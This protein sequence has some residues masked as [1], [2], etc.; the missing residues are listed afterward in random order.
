MSQHFKVTKNSDWIKIKRI[1]NF[2][3]H[4]CAVYL[5]HRLVATY[6]EGDSFHLQ[7][8]YPVH[9]IVVVG[10]LFQ[11]G[12]VIPIA[13]Q[14][15]VQT[16]SRARNFKSGDIL[17]ASDNVNE[18][19][20]GY[21]GHSAIVVSDDQLIESPGG[22]PAIRKASIQQFLEKHPRHAQF[23][24]KS[25]KL[26]KAAAQYAEEYLQE[27]KARVEKGEKKP[28]FSYTL[29]QSLEDP[30]EYIYCSKLVWLSYYKGADYKLENDYLWFSPEDL[31]TNLKDNKDFKKIYEHENVDFVVNT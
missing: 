6:Y 2:A 18:S 11:Y 23:R 3:F 5:D 29:S 1:S 31:Y 4:S 17:V 16:H 22:D 9:H 24:P 13:E 27:Y 19:L 28:V 12:H 21:I 20:T 8:N 15:F 26:G 10:H 7:I 14:F 25:A 30:W